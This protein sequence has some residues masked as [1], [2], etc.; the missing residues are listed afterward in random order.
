MTRPA[1][2]QVRGRRLPVNVLGRFPRLL[3]GRRRPWIKN[4]YRN[5]KII[6]IEG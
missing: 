5:I 4:S 2:V 3:V 6:V 1:A